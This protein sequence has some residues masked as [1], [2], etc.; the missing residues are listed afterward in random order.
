MCV[1][2]HESHFLSLFLSPSLSH[3][4][5]ITPSLTP[6]HSLALSHTLSHTQY[7]GS[8]PMEVS[9]RT[10]RFEDRTAVTR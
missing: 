1:C 10:L 8:L 4:F 5:S 2:E 3:S 9:M 6:S 7:V